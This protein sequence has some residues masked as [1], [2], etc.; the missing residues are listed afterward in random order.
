MASVIHHFNEQLKT[1]DE[2]RL[3]A[4]SDGYGDGEQVRDFIHVDDIVA[5]NLWAWE[6]RRQVRDLQPGYGP[7][8]Q[9]Q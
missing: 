1:G 7:G 8:P 3:F 5:V 2:I 4:G 9:L 6:H